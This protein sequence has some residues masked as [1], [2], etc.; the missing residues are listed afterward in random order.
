MWN[1]KEYSEIYPLVYIWHAQSR[2]I[3]F[4]I[5]VQGGKTLQVSID[6]QISPIFRLIFRFSWTDTTKLMN[7][8]GFSSF[9]PCKIKVKKKNEEINPFFKFFLSKFRKMCFHSG[10][11][12]VF[13]RHIFNNWSTFAIYIDLVI[14]CCLNECIGQV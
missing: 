1:G 10:K 14:R 7:I 8:S 12:A 3:E 5:N 2:V 4:Y 11:K 9:F 13:I 6:R